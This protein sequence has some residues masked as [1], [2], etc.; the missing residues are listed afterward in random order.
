MKEY[1]TIIV[2]YILIFLADTK[3]ETGMD[4]TRSKNE[5]GKEG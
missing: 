5:S 3:K 4:W 2:L 1:N